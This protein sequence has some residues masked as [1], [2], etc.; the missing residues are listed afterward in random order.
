MSLVKLNLSDTFLCYATFSGKCSRNLKTKKITPYQHHHGIHLTLE[1]PNMPKW[2]EYIEI[3]MGKKALKRRK[4]II[5]SV[6][7][8]TS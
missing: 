4:V 3:E 8:A 7:T 6:H 2:I 5:D 1:V